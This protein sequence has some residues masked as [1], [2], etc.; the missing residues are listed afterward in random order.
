M[1]NTIPAEFLSAALAAPPDRLRAALRVLRA[2]TAPP[3]TDQTL[4]LSM[5]EAARLLRVSRSTV[6]KLVRI[7]RLKKTRIYDGFERLRRA[8]V[9][10]L[11]GGAS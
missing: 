5:A 3:Q 4:F 1:K 9:E 11:A 2:E 10:A 6:W 7:G 8:D